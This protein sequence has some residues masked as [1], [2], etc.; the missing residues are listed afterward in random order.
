MSTPERHETAA[1]PGATTDLL[2]GGM[3]CAACVGRVEKKLGRVQGVTAT[4]NLATGRA[5]VSHPASVTAAQLISV[6]ESAGY[7][8]ELPPPPANEQHAGAA[9]E[10]PKAARAS[11]TGA[12]C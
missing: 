12:V 9:G 10:Q 4:V 1:E 11:L 5:R 6:V 2:V 8:A 3:T 7:T